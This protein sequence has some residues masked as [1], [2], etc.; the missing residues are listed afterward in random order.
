MHWKTKN[1][2]THS[3]QYLSVHM[4]RLSNK[5]T[6]QNQQTEY[7]NM[8]HISGSDSDHD[9]QKITRDLPRFQYIQKL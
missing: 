2:P 4:Q 7:K 1:A 6:K 8:T 9:N 3:M 5:Q